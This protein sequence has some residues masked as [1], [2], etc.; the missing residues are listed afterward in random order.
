[1]ASLHRLP[2]AVGER[3]ANMPSA[4]VQLEPAVVGRAGTLTKN[5]RMR[6]YSAIAAAHA[7]LVR[8]RFL[9]Q[10]FQGE[11][12]LCGT[13]GSEQPFAER[14]PDSGMVAAGVL[15]P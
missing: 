12:G 11:Q 5:L 2:S 9:A 4:S 13:A 15:R 7:P 8:G 14:S 3:D 6:R 10:V 1:M